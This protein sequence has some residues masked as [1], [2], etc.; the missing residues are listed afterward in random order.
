[1]GMQA[2]VAKQGSRCRLVHCMPRHAGQYAVVGQEGERCACI[3]VC[4]GTR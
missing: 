1:M 2:K 4:D 3:T